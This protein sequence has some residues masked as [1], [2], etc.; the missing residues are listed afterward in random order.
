[1]QTVLCTVLVLGAIGMAGALVLYLVAKK[2]HVEEDPRIGQI[3]SLLPGANCG[4]CGRKGCRDFACACVGKGALDGLVCPGTSDAS[5]QAIADILGVTAA[6]A[7][8]RVAVLKCNGSCA[9]RPRVYEYDGARSCAVMDAVGVGT[10]AC[11][12]GCLGCGDCVSVCPFGALSL[13]P[14]TE[15]PVVDTALCTGCGVCVAECPRHLLELR[16]V[17]RRDRR[18]WVA[19]SSRDRGAVA[20]KICAAACIG[21]GKC[22]KECP[23]GAISVGD[24]LAY[25]DADKCK[26]CGKCV[27]VC[28][29]G[30]IMDTFKPA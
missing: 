2:F 28:P 18:V 11:A 12:Y 22:S 19:C 7:E 17:G 14:E 3:E 16:P 27:A 9:A 6:A 15:L 30:A 13:N 8:R 10:S 26:T 23:F 1:M 4:A 21:C 5:L 20:R 25:I 29:T 24:N